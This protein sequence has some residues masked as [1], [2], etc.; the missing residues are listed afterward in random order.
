MDDQRDAVGGALRR[1]AVHPDIPGRDRALLTAPDTLLTPAYRDRPARRRDFLPTDPEKRGATIDGAVMGL[2][3]A[4]FTAVGGTIPLAIGVLIFQGPVGWQSASSH[5]ALLLAEIIALVTAVVFGVR[6]ARFGQVNGQ[7][8]AEVAARTHHGRY[9]TAADFDA[10]SRALLRRAQDAIDAVTSSQVYR[11]GLV[12]EPAV[13]AALTEHEW[14]IALAL[15]D[16]ARLRAR[17]SGLSEFQPGPTTAALLDRQVE[18]GQVETAQAET[19]QAEAARLAEAS[20]A[21]RVAA[22]ERY[23]AEVGEADAAYRD[24][25]R[26]AALAELSGRHLDMLARTAADEHGIAEIEAMSQRA[27]AIHLAFRELRD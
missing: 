26:A 19:A 14:D 16:Q 6:I 15:R 21:R 17:R 20:V 27:R 18:A 3:V 9:L 23:V 7:V 22:L 24:W 2:T 8:A 1:P 11:A 25:Q 4:A 5:Y 10:R 12:D 13:R